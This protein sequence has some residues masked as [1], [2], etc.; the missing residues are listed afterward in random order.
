MTTG[1]CFVIMECVD[2]KIKLGFSI[3]ESGCYVTQNNI[4]FCRTLH[5]HTHIM[6]K[7]YIFHTRFGM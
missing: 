2:R 5:T 7:Q 6:E 3:L 4:R 1:F